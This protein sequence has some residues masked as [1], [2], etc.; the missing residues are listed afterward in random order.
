MNAPTISINEQERL[1]ALYEY[2]IL[3]TLPEQEFDDITQL[4]SQICNTPI[5]LISLLDPDRQWF[6]SHFGLEVG[7][8]PRE[9]AFC[10]HAINNPDDIFIVSDS[11]LDERFADNPLV[12]GDPNVVFYAGV[13]L[14]NPN[15]YALG[16]LCIID[17]KPKTLTEGQINALK[18]LSKQV[19]KLLELRKINYKLNEKQIKL[20]RAI[21][22]F[23][24]T[25]KVAKV[26]GWEVDLLNKNLMWT[27]VTKEIHEVEM[28]FVPDLQTTIGFYKPGKDRDLITKHIIEAIEIGKSFEGDLQIVSAKGIE[29]WVRVKGDCEFTN[30]KCIRIYGIIQDINEEKLKDIQLSNSEEQFRQTFQQSTIGMALISPTGKWLKVNRSICSILG[31]DEQEFLNLSIKDI[32]LSEDQEISKSVMKDFLEGRINSFESESRYLHKDGHIVWTNLSVSLLKDQQGKPIH[33]IVQIIDITERKEA[34]QILNDERKLLIT[35]IDNI[36]INIYIKDLQSRKILV[37]Q[38]EIDHMGAADELEILGKNDFELYPNESALIS[39][40]E[41]QE[42]FKTGIP[43]I[44]RETY[45]FKND[46]GSH[47]FITSK[48]PLRNYNDEITGLLGIS[49]DITERNANEKKLKEMM[50]VT[51]QQNTRLQN[52]AHIVSHNLRSHSGNFAKLLEFI[53]L[54]EDPAEK[55]LLLQML[56]KASNNLGETVAHLNEIVAVNSNS[57]KEVSINLNKAIQEVQH[58]ILGLLHESNV[59]V[60]NEVDEKLNISAVPAYLESILLNFLTNG[61]KYKSTDKNAFVKF[62]AS[63]KGK[64]VVLSIEDNGLGIDLKKNK[65]KLF[66]MYKTFHGNK[67]AHGVGLYIT[68][69]QIEAMGGRVDVE[70][71][72]GIGTTFKIYFN[73]N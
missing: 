21:E 50:D 35:L 54:E 13:P 42:V 65:D 70:S 26:G 11:T 33:F 10:A 39:V 46:G 36:P 40:K 53:E 18:I 52:F 38:Q 44:N 34:V 47:W 9:L 8:T 51:I 63:Q 66:G 16:T 64:K 59:E 22:L 72:T 55:K 68:K 58:N 23:E 5:S 3:D 12:T 32:T 7:E 6:K 2:N 49:Y 19:I 25:G 29:K 69:N 20:D 27:T 67:D 56:H 30:N 45:N 61:I 48:I 1:K 28:D 37:N 24:Q 71:E 60:I 31:Y 41:D 62:Y 73:L 17:H 57:K 4:A 43:I 14:I 15:G